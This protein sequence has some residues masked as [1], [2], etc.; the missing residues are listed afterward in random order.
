[1]FAVPLI[2]EFVRPNEIADILKAGGF[3]RSAQA[4]R[5]PGGLNGLGRTNFRLGRSRWLGAF[6]D[7]PRRPLLR[8]DFRDSLNEVLLLVTEPGLEKPTAPLRRRDSEPL[9]DSLQILYREQAE[10]LAFL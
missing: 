7:R 1:V 9:F 4:G 10:D 8:G 3:T 2:R 6:R 5:P